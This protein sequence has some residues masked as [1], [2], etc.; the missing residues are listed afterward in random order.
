ME[1]K[2]H[3]KITHLSKIL[4]IFVGTRFLCGPI[5]LL[6]S[7]TK[8]LSQ[9]DLQRVGQKS[10]GLVTGRCSGPDFREIPVEKGVGFEYLNPVASH[11]M[12]LGSSD[13]TRG[14]L[15]FS[16]VTRRRVF[17]MICMCYQGVSTHGALFSGDGIRPLP[18]S[19]ASSFILSCVRCPS[20]TCR[21]NLYKTDICPI[22][23]IPEL[24]GMVDKAEEYG[25]VRG[26]ALNGN[27]SSFSGYSQ[28]LF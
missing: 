27:E 7:H 10:L 28:I 17:F 16:L 12:G 18:D 13:L 23:L 9:Y 25:S 24:W 21:V 14:P 3:K 26:R 15:R 4:N 22:S 11:P 2:N 6:G 5:M 1:I 19:L 20:S 8:D